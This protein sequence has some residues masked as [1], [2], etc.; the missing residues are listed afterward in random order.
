MATCDD[1]IHGEVCER[2]ANDNYRADLVH[3]KGVIHGIT[4]RVGDDEYEEIDAFG[5]GQV[6]ATNRRNVD[7]VSKRG[8]AQ[9]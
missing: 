9:G 3:G 5:G 6:N 2:R 8:E 7:W 1:C 4:K